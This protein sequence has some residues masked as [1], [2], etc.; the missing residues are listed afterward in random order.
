MPRKVSTLLTMQAHPRLSTRQWYTL[1]VHAVH[2]RDRT[3]VRFEFHVLNDAHQ[4]GRTVVYD[5]PAV[6]TPDSPLCRF[7]RNA[8]NL[9]LNLQQTLDLSTLVG[10]RLQV[11]F[12]KGLDDHLQAIVGVRPF[13][14]VIEENG[15]SQPATE[16]TE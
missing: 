5:L 13:E 3:A 8:F 1:E 12:D 10:R 7:L 6:L 16:Q 14:G 9:H 11:R 15:P 4:A 2:R